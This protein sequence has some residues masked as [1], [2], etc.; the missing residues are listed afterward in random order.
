MYFVLFVLK[1]IMD[2]LE[3]ANKLSNIVIG[4]AIEIHRELGP[5]LLEKVYQHC[6]FYELQADD[7]NIAMEVPIPIKYKEKIFEC[8]FN[9]DLVLEDCLII[10]LKTVEK[11]LPIHTAQLMTYLRLSGI[12]LGLL[13]NF[14][15]KLL[16]NGIKRVIV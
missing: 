10:E 1:Y 6:L 2:N 12:K 8:G 5:G 9:A 16:K 14:N 4:K 3:K 15:V 7:F 13:I 11:L